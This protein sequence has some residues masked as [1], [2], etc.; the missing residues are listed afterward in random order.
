MIASSPAPYRVLVVDDE[1]IARVGLRAMLARYQ[2][3]R[4]VGE[5]R[6]GDEAVAA[7]RTLRPD[8]VFLDIQMPGRDGFGVMREIAS[9]TPRPACVFVTAHAAYALDAYE[10]DAV[11]YLQKPFS[12]GRLARSVQRALRF[13]CGARAQ[14]AAPRVDRLLLRTAEGAVFVDV[15][16]ITRVSVA[17]NYVRFFVGGADYVVRRTMAEVAGELRDAGFVRISRSDLVNIARV[18][19]VHRRAGGRFDFELDGGSVTSSRRYQRD[20]RT[21][22]DGAQG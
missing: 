20:I 11:D 1:R 16:D 10:V 6:D 4:V 18:R 12:E 8:I 19:A 13:L 9:F 17:G 14:S 5:A 22:L 7:I 21:A 3:V 2:Q 15:A